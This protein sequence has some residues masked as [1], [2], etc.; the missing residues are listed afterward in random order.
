MNEKPASF[1]LS[2]WIC[3]LEEILQR[4][5]K[6]CATRRE[7]Q[8]AFQEAADATPAAVL[9]YQGENW[10]AAN[11]AAQLMTGYSS[12]ELF[13]MNILDI[14]HPDFRAMMQERIQKRLHEDETIDCGEMKIIVKDGTQKWLGE[15]DML[16]RVAGRPAGLLVAA[17]ISRRKKMDEALQNEKDLIQ[18]MLNLAGNVHLAYLDRDFN[19]VRVNETYA[20]GC[21]Y[22]A[23][24]LVG[25]N[26][27]DLFPNA[28]NEV[29][30]TRV[31]DTGESFSIRDKPFHYRYWPERGM[32]Y[33]DWTLSPVK[34]AGSL[35][36]GL[37]FSL[38]ETTERKKSEDRVH[39]LVAELRDAL[40]HVKTLRGSLPICAACKKIR[41]DE[42]YWERIETYIEE[43]SEAEFSH[44]MCPECLEKYYDKNRPLK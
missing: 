2:S 16:T 11:R 23:G 5:I 40:A 35:V 27:F 29:I 37:V 7:L 32:T 8:E 34:N 6:S 21:G 15:A 13:S 41:T 25:K 9:L 18:S 12:D 17:D 28:E 24:A 39:E 3:V 43:H 1:D 14:V 31:R 38:Y 22:S 44:S 19:F 4:R 26:H 36:V 42:G 30:F 33:W 10:I 20:T